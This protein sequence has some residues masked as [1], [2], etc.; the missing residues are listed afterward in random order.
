M[1]YRR[2][3]NSGL[4]VSEIALGGWLTLGGTVAEKESVNLILKGFE[5]GIN[6]FDIADVYSAGAIGSHAW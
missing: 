5:A 2:L 3:G 4:Q 6:L 1:R